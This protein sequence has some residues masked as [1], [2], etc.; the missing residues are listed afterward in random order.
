MI[1]NN[2]QT[3][4]ACLI[5][6]FNDDKIVLKCIQSVML[7]DYNNLKIYLVDN[8]S[9]YD[10]TEILKNRYPLI[11][12]IRI[13]E[14]M[15]Y[16][17]GF[18]YA[19]KYILNRGEKIDFFWLINNDVSVE[20]DAL[21]KLISVMIKSPD[22]GFIGPETFK[23]DCSGKH[24]QWIT[25]RNTK[26]NP[27][28]IVLDDE[29]DAKDREIIDVEF[30]VGHCIL[31]RFEVIKSV[32]MMRPGFFIYWEEVEWQ[33][34]AKLAGW[35]TV[36]CPGS[37]V[38]HDRDSFGKPFYNYLRTRNEIFFNRIVLRKEKGF[39]IIFIKN[40]RNV[41]IHCLRMSIT[42]CD[43]TNTKCYLKGF[44]HGFLKSVPEIE[45]L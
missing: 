17:G 26:E 32:G 36:V 18:N 22:I 33:W 5:L 25:K 16:A 4:V 44:F 45:Y 28:G 13:N 30:V 3:Q 14:N 15:G 42:N 40:I 31:I 23:R 39:K 11:N 7:S 20:K 19:M 35:K 9:D 43:W 21:S 1:K 24:D 34:R 29:I 27:A 12:Y 38:Y 8:G 2:N 10:L 6:T 41:F 37:I